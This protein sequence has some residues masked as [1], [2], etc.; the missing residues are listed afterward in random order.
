MPQFSPFQW[1]TRSIRAKVVVL[2]LAGAFFLVLAQSINAILA[3]DYSG[4]SEFQSYISMIKVQPA[5]MDRLAVSVLANAPDSVE[6]AAMLDGHAR[7]YDLLLKRLAIEE[8][9][10]AQAGLL[11]HER[12][13][14]RELFA[15]HLD[16]API[17]AQVDA[18]RVLWSSRK[19]VFLRV[20]AGDTTVSLA[21][22]D[23]AAYDLS[24][25]ADQLSKAVEDLTNSKIDVVRRTNIAVI[26]GGVA[27]A[28]L[29]YLSLRR[30]ILD[31]IDELRAATVRFAQGR[32]DARAPVRSEDELGK[33]SRTFNHMIETVVEREAMVRR[34]LD[35]IAAKNAELAK[36][37]QLKSQ[38]LASMSHELRTPMNSIIGYSEVLLDGLDG[39]LNAEQKEDVKAVLKAAEHLLKLINEVLD[40]SKIEAGHM[41]VDLAEV[42]LQDLVHDIRPTVAP[43]AEQK[44]LELSLEVLDPGAIVRADRDRLS[45]VVL[46]LLANA[47]KFTESGSITITVRQSSTHGIIDVRDTG[48]GIPMDQLDAVFREFH[49]VDGALTRKHGGTGLGLAISLKFIELMHGTIGVTSEPG[50]GSCFTVSL[51]LARARIAAESAPALLI[52][53]DDPLAVEL[54]RRHL[55]KAA[56]R[57]VTAGTL[58][59]ARTSLGPSSSLP[60]AILLDL[61]LPD[62]SGLDLLTELKTAPRTAG[63][64]VA[65]VSVADDDGAARKAGADAH[66]VKPVARQDLVA[67]V[68]KLLGTAP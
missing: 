31:P 26:L 48:I 24:S 58:A 28:L 59:E 25:Q 45:Q 54:Y 44:S 33:L 1:F 20:A 10:D 51:P 52:V 30:V 38:F 63:I 21:D 65:V 40:L 36:A 11:L 64:R 37:S 15:R 53:D 8:A 57:I 29:L 23:E 41:K 5:Q 61:N 50:K 16:D 19:P 34:N 49:Q 46:N 7:A 18:L 60:A 55:G 39:D 62:G 66:L 17:R 22:V 56:P 42:R 47:I 3:A 12:L 68:E 35:E 13:I 27:L 4:D 2:V 32:K 43:L 6:A 9:A 14:D 67:L